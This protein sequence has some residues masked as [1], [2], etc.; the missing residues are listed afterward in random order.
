MMKNL[1]PYYSINLILILSVLI[2]TGCA[3]PIPSENMVP[4]PLGKEHHIYSG[5]L[6]RTISVGEVGGGQETNPMLFPDIGNPQLEK[7]IIKSL[8][9]NN[10][11]ALS[12]ADAKYTLDVF[13]IEI[14]RPA[15][16]GI[17]MTVT[18]FVRYKITDNK[19]N[20]VIFDG[21]VTASDTKTGRDIFVA[22]TRIR[23]AQ[24]ESM[25]KNITK[26]LTMLFSLNNKISSAE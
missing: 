11:Y 6:Y 12:S 1:Y 19:D 26:F 9:N 14:D 25:K 17:T 5:H 2:I 7:A 18:T 22:T 13:L 16:G 4:P 15:Q 20:N 10:Y 24:E 21:I 8:E 23:V 3:K